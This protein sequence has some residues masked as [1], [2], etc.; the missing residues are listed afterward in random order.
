MTAPIR[1]FCLIALLVLSACA[2]GPL[3]PATPLGTARLGDGFVM[4][5]G[6]TKLALSTWRAHGTRPRA[7]ILALHGYGDYAIPT[8]DAAA[9]H[10]S[11]QGITTYAYDQRGFGRN[12]SRLRWPGPD[13]LEQDLISIARTVRARHPDTP[14]TVVGHSMGG[15]VVL[16]AAG[17]GL[18]A[19]RLVLAGPAIAGGSA[20]N[21]F[22]RFGGWG[23]GVLLPERR[24]TGEGVVEILPT[25]NLDALR[26]L[27]N[28]PLKIGTPSGRELFGLVRLMDRAARAAPSVSTPTLT[29]MGRKDQIFRSRQIEAV[30]DRIAGG[31]A[32]RLY[33][34]G[35]HWLF[36]DLQAALVWREVADFALTGRLPAERQ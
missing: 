34:E 23:I 6:D 10:W 4:G 19:D 11:R 29:L 27:S 13:L 26:R 35:W 31:A 22:L 30:H 16:A 12:A 3:G 25:D 24:F 32:F 21:P 7:I 9:R 20:L 1:I 36:R 33:P 18:A 2:G 8:F 15:G 17:R 14:L 5:A 28:D